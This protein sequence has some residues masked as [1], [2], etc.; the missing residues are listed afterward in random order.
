MDCGLSDFGI[1]SS[2]VD[3]HQGAFPT[4]DLTVWGKP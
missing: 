3:L 4:D 2:S 1:V